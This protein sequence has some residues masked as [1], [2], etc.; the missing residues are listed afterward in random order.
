MRDRVVIN[1]R[2]TREL[3]ENLDLL[4]K[5]KIFSSRAEAIR[6]FCREYIIENKG[7]ANQKKSREANL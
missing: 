5:K 3:A 1:V 7:L 4:I 2:L 6:E